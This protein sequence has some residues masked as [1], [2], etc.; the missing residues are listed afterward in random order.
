MNPPPPPP[1]QKKKKKKKKKIKNQEISSFQA[2]LYYP[3]T[4]VNFQNLLRIF[5]ETDK[6][7]KIVDVNVYWIPQNTTS[8]YVFR[9]VLFFVFAQG[10]DLTISRFHYNM[11]MNAYRFTYFLILETVYFL[12]ELKKKLSS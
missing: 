12:H 10:F 6:N 5:K 9:D 7:Q 8:Q 4:T 3:V 11:A 2:L 1:P